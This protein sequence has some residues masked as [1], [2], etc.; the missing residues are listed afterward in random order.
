MRVTTDLPFDFCSTCDKPS[1]DIR[2]TDMYSDEQ[3][4]DREVRI[5][6]QHDHICT[7][8]AD[9]LARKILHSKEQSAN[10]EAH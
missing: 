2:V 4:Y 7:G 9:E 10:E 8:V 6:C 3:V 5:Y 1:F